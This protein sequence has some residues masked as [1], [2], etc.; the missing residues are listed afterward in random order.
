[1]ATIGPK[2]TIADLTASLDPQLLV[3]LAADIL[4]NRGQSD[5]RL[6]D[7]PGDGCRDVH[8]LATNGEKHLAQCKFKEDPT[9]AA[10][11]TDLQEL[12]VALL[13]FGYKRGTFITNGKISPQAKRE[14]LDDYP[15]LQLEFLDGLDL[16]REILDSPLLTAL[17]VDGSDLRQPNLSV[18]YPILLRDLAQDVRVELSESAFK[19]FES[20]LTAKLS[21]WA[22][23]VRRESPVH[24]MRFDPYRPPSMLS[25]REGLTSR[26]QLPTIIL[27]G[28]GSLLELRDGMSIIAEAVAAATCD[29]LKACAVRV[30]TPEVTPLTGEQMGARFELDIVPQTY[31]CVGGKASSEVSQVRPTVN[32]PSL[33]SWV[34]RSD[35]RVSESGWVRLY[36]PQH[37]VCVDCRIVTRPSLEQSVQRAAIHETYALR[38]NQSKFILL[39][40][41]ADADLVKETAKPTFLV[42]I[43]QCFLA[44]WLHPDLESGALSFAG[45]TEGMPSDVREIAERLGV[46]TPSSPTFD[47][48]TQ[49]L[50]QKVSPS[51][52]RHLLAIH[53]KDP[54]PERGLVHFVTADVLIAFAQ[55][56][57]PLAVP[58]RSLRLELVLQ[59]QSLTV[60]QIKDMDLLASLVQAAEGSLRTS[61]GPESSVRVNPERGPNDEGGYF[62]VTVELPPRVE[63]TDSILNALESQLEAVI[64]RLCST[65]NGLA[66]G[67]KV[68]TRAYWQLRHNVDL[69]PPPGGTNKVHFWFYDKDGEIKGVANAQTG[70]V[71]VSESERATIESPATFGTITHPNEEGLML[72]VAQKPG[73]GDDK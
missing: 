48:S 67:W 45:E 29:H 73:K 31:W 18:E 66:E 62:A 60:A 68:A 47:S 35:A 12:P 22:H 49:E 23:V 71:A 26:L 41:Q 28:K 46:V 58:C 57:S 59:N 32:E 8:S 64:T 5:V 69:D 16:L 3:R 63:S 11:S 1:M 36:H 10:S 56:P 40:D 50:G 38:W 51:A 42:E 7:G 27:R 21:G 53:Y 37:D 61:L 25:T 6:V 24:M 52:A 4:C 70:Y 15:N 2:P 14:Y 33:H 19:V 9:K 34:E 17:W 44:G 72:L 43:G 39:T 54:F 20:E 30:G 65:M 13:K 55:L